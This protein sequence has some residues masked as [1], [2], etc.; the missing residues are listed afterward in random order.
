MKKLLMLSL[1]LIVFII[2]CSSNDTPKVESNSGPSSSDSNSEI[3]ASTGAVTANLS[4]IIINCENLV[5][6]KTITDLTPKRIVRKIDTFDNVTINKTKSIQRKTELKV[7]ESESEF[8][9]SKFD[10][11]TLTF[12]RQTIA[13]QTCKFGPSSGESRL[14]SNLINFRFVC[15][16][17][18]QVSQKFNEEK[19]SA[20]SIETGSVG[21]SSFWSIKKDET[22][23]SLLSG[24]VDCFVDIEGVI[25]LKLGEAIALELESKLG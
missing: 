15:G 10:T 14:G 12:D 18:D 16:P 22:V 11:K 24:K 6:L 25:D 8:A 21:I 20:R 1:I 7:E 4:P 3:S 13:E 5:S 17:K 23:Y 2:S 19:N 9:N